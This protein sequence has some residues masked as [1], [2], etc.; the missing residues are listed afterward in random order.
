MSTESKKKLIFVFQFK[1]KYLDLNSFLSHF[2]LK[3]V[4]AFITFS[5]FACIQVKREEAQ[6][7]LQSLGV[8]EKTA[9]FR[10]KYHVF[11]Q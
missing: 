7:S 11:P 10:N 1:G 8:N 4:L 9:I 2:R 5:Y 3:S 6:V